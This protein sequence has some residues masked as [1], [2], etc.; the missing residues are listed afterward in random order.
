ML[1]VGPFLG[2]YR[3]SA[4]TG[5]L[6]FSEDTGQLFALSALPDWLVRRN[7]DKYFDG[8]S[9]SIKLDISG[10]AALRQVM[11]TNSLLDQIKNGGLLVWPILAIAFF[12]LIMA[13]ERTV[14]LKRVH[15]NA[16]RLMDKVNTLARQG[17]WEDCEQALCSRGSGRPVCNVLRAGLEARGET[18]ETLESVLQEAI[19]RE[20]P[21]LD[22]FLPMLNM[23]GSVA[24]LLGLLGTVTGMI[25]TFD[26]ISLFGTGNAKAMAGGI[27]EAL[28]TTQS[29]L[30]AATPGLFMS[31]FLSRRAAK[32]EDLMQETISILKRRL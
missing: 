13:L 14:F 27:S 2:A 19:L 17:R 15:D 3:T 23:L 7:L 25:T 30:L 31:V 6:R 28:I 11:H 12:A 29:G 24:P 8:A 22:R 26:V 5:F 18:R 16:D 1:L 20:L 32:L 9:D 4:E 10:G 21:R